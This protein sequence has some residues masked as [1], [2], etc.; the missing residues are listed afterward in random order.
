MSQ[1]STQ[2]CTSHLDYANAILC[3][4]PDSTVGKLERVQKAAARVVEGVKG[5]ASVTQ[6]TINLHW[7]PIRQRI[8]FKIS[9][10]VHKCLL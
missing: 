4:L 5:K 8:N 6:A 10:L 1:S 3:K 7:L 9:T 2:S